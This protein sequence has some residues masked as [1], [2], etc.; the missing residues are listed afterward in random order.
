MRLPK[1]G[2]QLQWKLELAVAKT[3][4]QAGRHPGLAPV[5]YGS[6]SASSGGKD[7]PLGDALALVLSVSLTS[8]FFEPCGP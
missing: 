2:P 1:R 3:C 6:R 7:V 5:F 4:G 8:L